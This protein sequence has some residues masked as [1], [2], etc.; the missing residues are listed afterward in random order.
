MIMV[1]RGQPWLLVYGCWAL[2][3]LPRSVLGPEPTCVPSRVAP[4][5]PTC[6][7]LQPL[8]ASPCHLP[9]PSPPSVDLRAQSSGATSTAANPPLEAAHIIFKPF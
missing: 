3:E 1:G 7:V 6:T 5:R 2:P 4:A 9:P 8:D